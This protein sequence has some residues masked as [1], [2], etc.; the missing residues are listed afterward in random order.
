MIMVRAAGATGQSGRNG[1]ARA[2][3]EGGE[4]LT[5][6]RRTGG[7]RTPQR[8]GWLLAMGYLGHAD[9]VARCAE[10]ARTCR[11][12]VLFGDRD[13]LLVEGDV[14]AVVLADAVLP[15]RPFAISSEPPWVFDR[16][17]HWREHRTV[18]P[19]T[20]ANRT[21]WEAASQKHVREYGDLLAQA[22]SGSS[23][24]GT[25]RTSCGRYCA[26]RPRSCTCRAVTAWMMSPSCRRGR[27]PW[28]ESTTARWPSAPRSAART[29]S[30]PPAATSSPRFPKHR[31]PARAPT[32]STPGK[33]P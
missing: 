10:A 22:A 15:G 32:W 9:R 2:R 24:T 27:D 8:A 5:A 6:L 18:D 7:Y 33:A 4:R 23:L 16:W 20:R 31:W 19:V 3:R 21:A 26:A 29:S 30:A 14:T 25:E 11:Y 13:L 12:A 1:H 17:R 28:S